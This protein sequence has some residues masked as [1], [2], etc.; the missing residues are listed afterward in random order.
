MIYLVRPNRCP[1]QVMQGFATMLGIPKSAVTNVTLANS[2][3]QAQTWHLLASSSSVN[4]ITAVYH[5]TIQPPAPSN[6][7]NSSAVAVGLLTAP[8]VAR[9][10]S[11]AEPAQSQA[12]LGFAVTQVMQS[13]RIGL[14]GNGICEVGERRI[15]SNGSQLALQG[16]CP[17][18]CPLQY[19]QCPSSNSSIT[20]SERG[21]CLS[22]QGICNCFPG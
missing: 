2:S 6:T 4:A 18:D 7:I 5:V 1:V 8:T 13:Y 14:C 10:L 9:L 17:E 12:A 11:S 3:Q 21:S 20:C 19:I 16:T 22:S 15:T